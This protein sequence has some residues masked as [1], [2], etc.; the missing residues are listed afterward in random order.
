MKSINKLN[1]WQNLLE[2]ELNGII[3]ILKRSYKPERIILYGSASQNRAKEWS[4]LDLVIIKKT[5]RR[6]YDRISEVSSLITHEVPVD[7]LVYTPEEFLSMAKTNYFIR[8][9]VL[10]RGKTIYES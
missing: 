10:K 8:D 2:T 7:I 4:D 6:F 5:N 9:E 3:E 1:N